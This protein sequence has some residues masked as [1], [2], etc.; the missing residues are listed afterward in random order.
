MKIS[1][2][3]LAVFFGRAGD[4]PISLQLEQDGLRVLRNTGEEFLPFE[5]LEELLLEKHLCWASV[6][7]WLK[8]GTSLTARGFSKASATAFY[9]ESLN[10]QTAHGEKCLANELLAKAPDIIAL[11]AQIRE[12]TSGSHYLRYQSC[13]A[14]LAQVQRSGHLHNV[15]RDLLPSNGE[16]RADLDL[17]AKFASASDYARQN[18]NRQFAQNE[19]ERFREFFDH[20]EANPL[21]DAQRSAVV[22]DEDNTLVIAG[23]GSGKTSVIVAKAGYLIKRERCKPEQILLLAFNRDAKEEIEE[24]LERRVGVTLKAATFHSLG[25][26]V[27]ASVEGK[28]PAVSAE[29]ADHLKMLNLLK[30]IMAGLQEK[31]E[32]A[33]FI[34]KFFGYYLVP[35][36]DL[37]DFKSQGDYWDYLQAREVRSLQ[38]DIVKSLRN[39]KSPISYS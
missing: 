22:T 26:E 23:A 19:K 30:D 13:K 15:R 14:L 12:A 3:A 34:R 10:T 27:I 33:E 18:C 6:H 36:R 8:D 24:R 35:Y 38:A 21:T 29:A 39:W 5:N 9:Q 7:L 20:I 25:L 31:P 28:K 17:I 1:P 16:L 2:A 4:S 32:F 11:A 37:F